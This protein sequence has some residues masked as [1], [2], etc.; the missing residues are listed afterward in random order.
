MRHPLKA[1]FVDRFRGRGYQNSAAHRNRLN[2]NKV[3]T[4]A[5]VSDDEAASDNSLRNL[6]TKSISVYEALRAALATD[7][8][9]INCIL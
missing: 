4:T 7:H 1:R 5:F 2:F 3:P 6:S 9:L 8:I